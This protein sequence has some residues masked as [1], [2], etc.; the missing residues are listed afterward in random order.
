MIDRIYCR[1]DSHILM[2]LPELYRYGREKLWFGYKPFFLYI[3][4]GIYQA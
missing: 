1:I 3:I 2:A 4:D